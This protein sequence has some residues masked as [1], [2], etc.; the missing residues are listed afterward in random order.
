[1]TGPP[2]LV[3]FLGDL[4]GSEVERMV[5][6]ARAAAAFDTIA[7]ALATEAFSTAIVV[8]DSRE[9]EAPVPGV[10]I[11]RD[12]EPYHFGER[13]AGV[14]GAVGASGVVYLGGGAVPLMSG[15]EIAMM[16]SRSSSGTAVTNNVYSSDAAAFPVTEQVLEAIRPLERDNGL[17]KALIEAGLSVEALS[18][19]AE[20]QFDIDTPTDLAVLALTGRGGLRLREYVAGV[21]IET[22]PYERVL[23]LF[24]DVNKQVVVAGRVGSHAWA[25]LERETACRV[26][27]FAEERGM[28]A[29]GRAGE[30]RVRSLLGFYLAAAGSERFFG[31]LP[32]L[33]DAWFIDTRVLLAH[34]GVEASRA[35]RFNSDLGRWENVREPWLRDFTRLAMECHVPV[36]LGGHSLMSGGL[37]ALNEHAWSLRDARRL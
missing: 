34:R 31:T 23:P 7:A 17:G 2:L 18:R 32:E 21:G 4:E 33:G 6:G 12:S 27:L 29:D 19:T 28:E 3:V 14:L 9:L 22:S 26:R 10:T 37:M 5:S 16:G 20:T 24:L 36:L 11:D 25:Y 13:L 8:T 15:A 35:D 1:L 30:R